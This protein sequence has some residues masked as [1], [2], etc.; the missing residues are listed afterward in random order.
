M[1]PQL[2]VDNDAGAQAVSSRVT[3]T[4]LETGAYSIFVT[5]AESAGGFWFGSGDGSVRFV[6]VDRF[7]PG[8][9]KESALGATP[10]RVTARSSTATPISGTETR[11]S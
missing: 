3:V 9:V 4:S 8:A 5:G 7:S 2:A 6:P 11:G 1:Y 10:L